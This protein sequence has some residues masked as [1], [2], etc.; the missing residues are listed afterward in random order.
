MIHLADSG[1]VINYPYTTLEK[2]LIKPLD[3]VVG[4]NHVFRHHSGVRVAVA[5]WR[6]Y[7]G[8]GV[9]HHPV[10]CD[11]HQVITLIFGTALTEYPCGR[12]SHQIIPTNDACL[13]GTDGEVLGEIMNCRT[14]YFH[15][16]A[17][18]HL[19]AMTW[20]EWLLACSKTKLLHVVPALNNDHTMLARLTLGHIL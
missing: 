20:R 8:L 12:I 14:D 7:S 11:H 10:P 16:L 17:Q 5:D 3:S 18:I 9:Y 6:V 2:D 1:P 15:H 13:V 4:F 19:S